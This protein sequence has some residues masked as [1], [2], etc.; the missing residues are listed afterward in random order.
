MRASDLI[1]E[2]GFYI[3]KYG[4]LPVYIPDDGINDC[5]DETESG[6]IRFYG[7]ETDEYYSECCDDI[8]DCDTGICLKCKEHADAKMVYPNRFYIKT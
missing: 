6:G 7:E 1:R 8:R 4:D 2:L 3:D 5:G